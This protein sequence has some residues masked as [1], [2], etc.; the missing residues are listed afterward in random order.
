MKRVIGAIL[1]VFAVLLYLM[2]LWV[3]AKEVHYSMAG[4]WFTLTN[5]ALLGSF[6]ATGLGALAPG[7][8]AHYLGYR[9]RRST[10]ATPSE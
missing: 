9:L 4:L 10:K 5:G 8:I 7:A 6:I 2:G 3:L 1:I